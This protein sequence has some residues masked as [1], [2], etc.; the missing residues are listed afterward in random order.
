MENETI[1]VLIFSAL[2][3]YFIWDTYAN[4]EV[5]YVISAIDNRKY[6]VRSLPDKQAAADLLATINKNFATLLKHLENTAPSD[7]RV[8]RMVK[9]Y[10]PNA[11]SEG[12]DDGKYT[13]YSVN[14][15]EK[16]VFCLRA[17]DGTNKLEDINTMMFVA[18]HEMAHLASESIGHTKEFW[19]NFKWILLESINIGLYQ[20]QDYKA[21]PKDYCGIKITDSPLHNKI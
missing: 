7:D 15:G 6:S 11:L 20:D 17:R 18:L 1:I 13:S 14:K 4:G 21:K 12:A 9:N 10:R 2:L 16:L 19:H 5:E 3:I 8:F